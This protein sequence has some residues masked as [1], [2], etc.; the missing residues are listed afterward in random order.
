V[1]LHR[2]LSTV[3]A[4]FE[5]ANIRVPASLDRLVSWLWVTP[6]LHKRHHSRDPR[7]TDTNYGN[8][9]AVFDRLLATFTPAARTAPVYG[10][11][12]ADEAT[13]TELSG[14]LRA[15]FVARH[16]AVSF[17]ATKMV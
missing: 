17:R 10:L 8:L 5:H 2:V 15:P 4:V 3:N 12:D 14:L 11:D 9:F 1:A 16:T 13:C 7:E 6:D